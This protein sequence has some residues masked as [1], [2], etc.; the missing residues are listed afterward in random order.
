MTNWKILSLTLLIAFFSIGLT[1]QTEG[2][3]A[4]EKVEKVKKNKKEKKKKGETPV[5]TEIK[6]EVSDDYQDEEEE[7]ELE[8][9]DESEEVAN[10]FKDAATSRRTAKEFIADGKTKEAKPA[11]NSAKS[12]YESI[13]LREP[14]SYSAHYLLGEVFTM[15]K[16]YKDAL[17]MFNKAIGLDSSKSD[18]YRERANLNIEKKE[19][20]AAVEDF[21]Q[22]IKLNDED[23]EAFY[24]RGFLK[25]NA[26]DKKEAYNDFSSAIELD[27]E[28]A[29]AY[30]YRG[31]ISCDDQRDYRSAELDFNEVIELDTNNREVNFWLGKTY[32]KGQDFT[33]AAE[34]LTTYTETEGNELHIESLIMLGASKLNLNKYQESVDAFTKVIGEDKKNFI[35]YM[36][37]GMAK[38]GLRKYDEALQDLDKAVEYKFNFSSIYI[39]RALVKFQKGDSNGACKDLKLAQSLNNPKADRLIKEYCMQ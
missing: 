39:N 16:K 14:E 23:S 34:F 27:P 15:Q 12:I 24:M 18:A 19:F 20:Y 25:K 3:S 30:F 28:Y 8:S 2:G 9:L 5:E 33:K 11:L 26:K 17:N 4:E 37:R 21:T 1:A 6:E 32:F 29:D 38:A 10:L 13:I 36:N 31:I 7:V 35:A 22:A